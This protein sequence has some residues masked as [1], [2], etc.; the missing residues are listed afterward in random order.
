MP[1]QKD[2]EKIDV[3]LEKYIPS[4]FK[5]REIYAKLADLN[6][7]SGETKELFVKLHDILKPRR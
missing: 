3:M 5:R 7:K 1:K 4:M 6:L 2:I